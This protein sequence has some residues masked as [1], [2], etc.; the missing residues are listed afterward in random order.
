M[1]RQVIPSTVVATVRGRFLGTAFDERGKLIAVESY[2]GSVPTFTWRSDSGHLFFYLPP[3]AF[4]PMELRDTVDVTC[5]SPCIAINDLRIQG[6]G[7]ATIGRSTDQFSW[8]RYVCSIDWQDDNQL[9]HVVIDDGGFPRIVRNTR[10]Q[11]GGNALNLPNWKKG[12]E[13]WTV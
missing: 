1:N 9:V 7:F 13:E 10:F 2:R 5:P 6:G 4:G 11:I 8:K 3:H 12:R